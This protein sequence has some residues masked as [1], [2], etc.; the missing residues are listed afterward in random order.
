MTTKKPK[1]PVGRPPKGPPE[2]IPDTEQNVVR[3]L[4]KSRPKDERDL[5]KRKSASAP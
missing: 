1:R 4:V 5:L 3:S 2:R